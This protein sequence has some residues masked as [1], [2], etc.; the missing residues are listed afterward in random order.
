MGNDPGWQR[1]TQKL[2]RC[3]FEGRWKNKVT[4]TEVLQKVQENR[5]VLNAVQQRKLRQI[6][7]N[8]GRELL[9]RDI[10]KGRMLEKQ[11]EEENGYVTSRTYED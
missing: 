10:I 4:G 7:R 8:L 1:K 2:L 3:V 11:Q 6:W 9:L 5:N